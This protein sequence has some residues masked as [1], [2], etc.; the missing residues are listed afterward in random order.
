[1][2]ELKYLT[3]SQILSQWLQL[4]AVDN[5]SYHLEFSAIQHCSLGL[6]WWIMSQVAVAACLHNNSQIYILHDDN[7][8]K[9]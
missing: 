3:K 4:V 7:I 8:E 1:M 9:V 2:S 5:D 6:Q